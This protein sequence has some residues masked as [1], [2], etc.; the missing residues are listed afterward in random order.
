MTV[1]NPKAVYVCFSFPRL[2]N[3]GIIDWAPSASA[4]F[5][6][7]IPR[8][9]S[10]AGLIGVMLLSWI[11]MACI[12]VC[13]GLPGFQRRVILSSCKSHSAFTCHLIK[14]DLLFHC[15]KVMHMSRYDFFAAS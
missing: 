14:V 1:K 13:M 9:A 8:H 7:L 6:S 4:S 5:R 10:C 15:A 12:D 3:R 11:S 2:I